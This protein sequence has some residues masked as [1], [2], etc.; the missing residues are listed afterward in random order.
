[1]TSKLDKS[2][3]D[4][5]HGEESNMKHEDPKICCITSTDHT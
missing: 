1:V 3:P 4:S 2:I 5:D